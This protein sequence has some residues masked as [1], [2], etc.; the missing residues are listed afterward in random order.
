MKT[1]KNEVGGGVNYASLNMSYT[2]PTLDWRRFLADIKNLQLGSHV[3]SY[4]SAMLPPSTFLSGYVTM[5]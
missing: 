4:R 3:V 1:L 5:A 2:I